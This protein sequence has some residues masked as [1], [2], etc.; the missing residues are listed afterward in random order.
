L[1]DEFVGQF[2]QPVWASFVTAA[3]LSRAVPAPRDLQPGSADDALFIAQSMPWIDPAK[4]AAAYVTL[5]RAGFASEV[6]VMRKRGVNPR[7]VLEQITA[8]RAETEARD[9]VFT[10]NG[11]NAE[12]GGNAS[13]SDAQASESAAQQAAEDAADRAAQAAARMAAQD[14][15]R[16]RAD[17]NARPQVAPV[18]NVHVPEQRHEVHNHIAPSA[19][20]VE[21]HNQVQVPETTVNVEAVM[22]TAAAPVVNVSNTVEPAPVTV[23]N[24]HPARAVQTVERDDNDEIVRTVTTY[25]G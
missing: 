20:A 14:I 17:I 25:E 22:P 12:S 4:E 3:Q 10:S 6:E 19:A 16:L 1:T 23:H 5:V 9:L 7:D 21:V 8:F 13:A 18:V 2:I 15:E 11:R 24:T